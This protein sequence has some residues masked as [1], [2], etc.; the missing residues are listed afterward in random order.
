MLYQRLGMVLYLYYITGLLAAARRPSSSICYLICLFE[1]VGIVGMC[2][3]LRLVTNTNTSCSFV[4]VRVCSSSECSP[5]WRS[6][7]I[8]S[9]DANRFNDEQNH[10][11]HPNWISFHP[12]KLIYVIDMS[13][14]CDLGQT[15]QTCSLTVGQLRIIFQCR[16]LDS[17][18]FVKLFSST[19]CESIDFQMT[20]L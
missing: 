12:K 1:H 18:G 11:G 9:S 5:D 13:N 16:N 19:H 20:T 14:E 2:Y 7:K 17:F 3:V 15:L 6:L 10:L 8:F 4:F